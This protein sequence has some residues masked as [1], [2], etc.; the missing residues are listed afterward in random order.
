MLSPAGMAGGREASRV[1]QFLRRQIGTGLDEA[2]AV[3]HDAAAQ[4]VCIRVGSGHDKYVS[5]ALIFG[6]I[7][8]IVSPRDSF[9][10][11]VAFE[12]DKLCMCE[13]GDVGGLFDTT[14]QVFR[15]RFRQPGASDEDVNVV[16]ALGEKYSRLSCGI[17]RRRPRLCLRRCIAAPQ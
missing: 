13:Q 14:D 6:F 11:V 7:G 5:N 1:V 17:F 3:E 10:V 2:F 8:L 4:P 16:C 15:H 9:Q 12:I